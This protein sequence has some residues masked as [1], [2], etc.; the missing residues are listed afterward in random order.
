MTRPCG[1]R[2]WGDAAIRDADRD[3]SVYL[4]SAGHCER[5]AIAQKDPQPP[6]PSANH[7][8]R[9]T[10]AA[11]STARDRHA[12]RRSELQWGTTGGTTNRETALAPKPI[13]PSIGA[14]SYWT[15]IRGLSFAM[16][17]DVAGG[18]VSRPLQM[19][20][21]PRRDMRASGASPHCAVLCWRCE[22]LSITS[23]RARI[24]WL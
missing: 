1:V 7:G 12:C 18:V 8:S 21:A 20:I 6:A 10:P 4:G 9:L 3:S 16:L 15:A 5:F 2:D 23:R 17:A 14:G 19:I 11:A 24:S 22:P 13:L